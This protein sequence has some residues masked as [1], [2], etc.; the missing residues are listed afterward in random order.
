[1]GRAPVVEPRLVIE[2]DGID[3]QRVPF[4]PYG[5]EEQKEDPNAWRDSL[6]EIEKRER[7]KALKPQKTKGFI[8]R[9]LDGEK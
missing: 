1:M 7:Q 5:E 3:H 4:V 8:Y 6:E 2:A 9:V